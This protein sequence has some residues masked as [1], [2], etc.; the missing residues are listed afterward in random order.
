MTKRRA[1]YSIIFVA[2]LFLLT[3]SIEIAFADQVVPDWGPTKSSL[4]P[5]DQ[6]A[7]KLTQGSNNYNPFVYKIVNQDSTS[8]NS[9]GLDTSWASFSFSGPVQVQVTA[10]A[11]SAGTYNSARILPSSAGIEA[12]VDPHS[13]TA[14]FML[15]QPGQFAVG[16]CTQSIC[17]ESNDSAAPIHPVMVFANP[18][19]NPIKGPIITPGI[20]RVPDPNAQNVLVVSPPQPG[21]SSW[22]AL[23]GVSSSGVIQNVLYFPSGYVYPGQA[24]HPLSTGQSVYI[25]PGAYVE[26]TF[27]LADN[28]TNASIY[29]RGTISGELISRDSCIPSTKATGGCP[30]MIDGAKKDSSKNLVEGITL[31]QSPFYNVE[32]S[33]IQNTARNIKEMAWYVNTDAIQVAT[34]IPPH[35]A[36]PGSIVEDSFFKVNDDTIHLNSSNLTVRNCTIW[37]LVNGAPFQLGWDANVDRH[38]ITVLDSN[39][40][41]TEHK[42]FDQ[43]S[44]IF[45]AVQGGKGQLDNYLFKNINVENSLLQLFEVTIRPSWFPANINPQL[46]S[47]SGLQFVN[48]QVT[49]AQLLPSIFQGYN[50]AHPVSNVL[51]NNVVVNGQTLSQPTMTYDAN[52]TITFN[53]PALT[54]VN[55]LQEDTLSD[56]VWRQNNAQNIPT[57]N[58]QIWTMNL[59]GNPTSFFICGTSSTPPCYFS[60]VFSEPNMTPNMQVLAKGDFYGKGF[61]S[62]LIQDNNTGNLGIWQDPLVTLQKPWKTKYAAINYTPPAPG[63]KYWQVVGTGDFNGDGYTDIL[64]WNATSQEGIVLL[65]KG[66]LVTGQISI[67]PTHAA[68]APPWKFGG[69]GDFDENGYSDIVL[70]DADNNIEILYM[71]ASGYLYS[72]DFGPQNFGSGWQM[73]GVGDVQ[74]DGYANILWTNA[75]TSQIGYS[76]FNNNGPAPNQV[77][78]TTILNNP[79]YLPTGSSISALGDYNGDASMDMLLNIPGSSN[80]SAWYLGLFASNNFTAGP[81]PVIQPALSSDWQIQGQ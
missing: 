53:N 67:N 71:G 24:G 12:T 23:G 11:V 13:N 56:I 77:E 79:P 60:T 1:L 69:I 34:F 9:Q 44:G 36:D 59:A 64:L 15:S 66:A 2:G 4:L 70:F 63:W 7:V 62:L 25:A 27:A 6:Y 8:N 16:F 41:R 49:D 55:N 26:G 30:P 42:W 45:V 73:A 39:V 21:T 37:Q 54:A 32:L 3:V 58:F 17:N 29:G 46:G 20:P 14:T 48:I 57:T 65:M 78:Y 75:S 52:R 19:E 18:L 33:G 61:A 76:L 43:N 50:R 40:I 72:S 28:T 31:V 35:V 51:F 5:S 80:V 81:G 68:L 10:M 74:G 22:P 47:I 38:H